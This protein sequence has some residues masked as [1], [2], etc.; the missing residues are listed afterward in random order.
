MIVRPLMFLKDKIE[1]VADSELRDKFKLTF[2][3]T[4]ILV[5]IYFQGPRTQANLARFW[6]VSE[7]SIYRQVK[8]LLEKKLIVITPDAD[9]QRKQIIK[10]TKEAEKI[11]PRTFKVLD[12]RMEKIFRG[13][14][15]SERQS[16]VQLLG[17]FIGCIDEA[18]PSVR[19][20]DHV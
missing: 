20:F 4:K 19:K 15:N 16:L 6:N 7:A 13:I 1:L 9:D 17:L 8:I 10:L 12:E 3:Q 5:P 2:A 11:I 18:E 14:S